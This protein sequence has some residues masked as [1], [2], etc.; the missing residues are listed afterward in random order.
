MEKANKIYLL[1]TVALNQFPYPALED[2]KSTGRVSKQVLAG[3]GS[4]S[5]RSE[6][7]ICKVHISSLPD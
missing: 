5:N 7:I 2:R 3:Q 4:Y 1:A 6:S